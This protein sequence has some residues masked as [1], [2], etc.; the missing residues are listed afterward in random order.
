MK[1]V[2]ITLL[3]TL[4]LGFSGWAYALSEVDCLAYTLHKEARG[5]SLRG[6]RAVLDVIYNRMRI[7]ELTA[8]Q[9]MKQRSQFSW[10]SKSV[11]IKMEIKVL[12][13][14]FIVDAMQPVL[15]SNVE[16]FHTRQIRPS[17]TRNL[18]RVA[19]IGNHVF[20]AEK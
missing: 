14:F 10:Y 12:T 8:C 19:I 6:R 7:R 15:P 9:V 2:L 3:T 17:W 4:M 18:K 11:K 1:R 5:E 13:E 16:Y 20:L